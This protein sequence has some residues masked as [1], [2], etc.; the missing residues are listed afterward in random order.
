MGAKW[1]VTVDKKVERK[2]IPR[3]SHELQLIVYEAIEDLKIEGPRPMGWN[4]KKLED[5]KY[6]L[7]LKREYRMI[8]YVYKEIITIEIIFAGHRKE[9]E[10]HY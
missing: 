5:N 4:V 9:A 6:R 7:R 1:I 8:Y 3:L 10:K 2:Q